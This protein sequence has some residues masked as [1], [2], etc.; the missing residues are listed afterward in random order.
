MYKEGQEIF[1]FVMILQFFSP[2]QT[3]THVQAT[4][5]VDMWR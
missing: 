4:G 3:H 1:I 5:N 2:P